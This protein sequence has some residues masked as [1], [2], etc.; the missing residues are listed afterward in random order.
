MVTIFDLIDT[1]R[2]SFDASRSTVSIKRAV[3][4]A[5]LRMC[6][7]TY[8]GKLVKLATPIGLWRHPDFVLPLPPIFF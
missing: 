8:Y 7:F 5:K 2:T 1:G 6:T 4:W 3:W